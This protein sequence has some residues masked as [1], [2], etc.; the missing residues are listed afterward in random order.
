MLGRVH[1]RLDQ[2]DSRANALNKTKAIGGLHESFGAQG[3]ACLNPADQR[4]GVN[5]RLNDAFFRL[6][7]LVGMWFT[8]R[9]LA[10]SLGKIPGIRGKQHRRTDAGMNGWNDG[11]PRGQVMYPFMDPLTL[12]RRHEIHFVQDQQVGR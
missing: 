11:S 4:L 1:G 7:R 8:C 6:K 9:W 3:V 10:G 2:I 12:F 5:P